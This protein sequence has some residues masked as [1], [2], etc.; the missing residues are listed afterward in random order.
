MIKS[1]CFFFCIQSSFLFRGPGAIFANFL[2]P[3][4]KNFVTFSLKIQVYCE[5]IKFLKSIWLNFNNDYYKNKKLMR[6]YKKLLCKSIYKLRKCCQVTK[7]LQSFCEFRPRCFVRWQIDESITAAICEFNRFDLTDKY[8][9]SLF[10]SLT[11]SLSF[12]RTYTLSLSHIYTLI[13]AF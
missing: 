6:Y 2:S 13:N 9:N 7:I 12:I 5:L 11:H 10:L 1:I 3:I 8:L 4:L